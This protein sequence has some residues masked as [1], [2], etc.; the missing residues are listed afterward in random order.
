MRGSY[1]WHHWSLWSHEKLNFLYLHYHNVNSDEN[2]HSGDLTWGSLTHKVIWPF[3]ICITGLRAKIKALYFHYHNANDH[4]VWRGE[5]C[6]RGFLPI[7]PINFWSC[8]LPRSRDKLKTFYLH[9]HSA[10]DHQNRW[11][12]GIQ[13]KV[14]LSSH[15]PLN[16]WHWDV[17]WQIKYMISLFALDQ[18]PP[19]IQSGG[20]PQRTSTIKV[21]QP[22]IQM[23]TCGHVRSFKSIPFFT[24]FIFTKLARVLILGKRF[25]R[26]TPKLS[27][28]SGLLYSKA[29]EE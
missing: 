24:I 12:G 16:T 13:W 28:T 1:A 19:H 11:T 23:V 4:Q 2:W 15:D 8:G 21:T 17:T 20:L 18:W 22:F 9:Y 26:Q 6:I 3:I 10:N 27:A 5:I 29:V 7:T 25:R 14:H